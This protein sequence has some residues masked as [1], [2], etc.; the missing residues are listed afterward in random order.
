MDIKHQRL[1]DEIES[2]KAKMERLARALEIKTRALNS[3]HLQNYP[4]CATSY[5]NRR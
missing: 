1:V 2:I 3:K 5:G 4:V